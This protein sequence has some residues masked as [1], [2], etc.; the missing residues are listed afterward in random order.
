[1]R[2]LTFLL[3]VRFLEVWRRGKYLV[4]DVGIG[5]V[6]AHL[7]MSGSLRIV[8]PGELVR[9]HD[10]LDIEFFQGNRFAL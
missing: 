1:M 4:I 8:N 7:G 2:F 3:A 9:T 5:S 10:H 6:I